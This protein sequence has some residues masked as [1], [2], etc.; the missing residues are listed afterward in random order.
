MRRRWRVLKALS[1]TQQEL[2]KTNAA[3][4]TPSAAPAIIQNL[5]QAQP[6]VAA[7]QFNFE[8]TL[9]RMQSSTLKL[10]Q[11]SK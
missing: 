8:N 1:D 2:I 3:P 5:D 4:V 7:R 10:N 11:I 9:A 6:A